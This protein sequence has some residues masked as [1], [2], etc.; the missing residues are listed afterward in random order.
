MGL[1]DFENR[2]LITDLYQLTMSASYFSKKHNPQAAFEMFI[3]NLPEHR[4]YLVFA[5]LEQALDYLKSLKFLP[6][7]INYL[8]SL[9]AFRHIPKE[10]WEYLEDFKFTGEVWALD[11]GEPFFAGE[12]ILQ[13]RAPLIQAQFVETYLLAVVNFQ[14]LIATKATRVVEAAKGRDVVDFG[15]RRAHGPEASVLA[16]RAAVIGGCATTSNVYAA[17]KLGLPPSGTM[18]HSYIMSFEDDKAAFENYFDDFPESAVL[19]LD[20]YDTIKAAH[21]VAEM[22]SEPHGIRLDSGDL[23][24]LSKSVRRILDRSGKRA[25]KIFASGDLNEYLIDELVRKKAPI[26]AFGVGTELVTSKDA[27]ALGGIYKLA[28]IEDDKRTKYTLKLSSGKATYPGR[29]QIFRKMGENGYYGED[30]ICCADEK[31]PGKPLLKKV[32]EKG[33]VIIDLPEILEIQ[34]KTQREMAK[35]APRVKSLASPG[36]YPVKY[37]DKLRQLKQKLAREIRRAQGLL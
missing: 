20:T 21:I 29:K 7:E 27:P 31:L 8:R 26:D 14:T 18:A 34:K 1:L 10:F 3:R 16:A 30:V 28:E 6:D 9:P 15:A 2:A 13:V 32:M 37:S 19:L 33:K 17:R 11:E 23:L 24:T 25:T 5:G 36:H 35:I 4:G 12:P 22:K